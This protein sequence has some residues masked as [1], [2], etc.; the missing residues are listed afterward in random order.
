[1][2]LG[3]QGFYNV[4]DHH[5]E[6]TKDWVVV[7]WNLGNRC[8]YT[9]S[10]CPSILNDGSYGW[11][12]FEVVK[13]FIDAVAFH[14]K[15]R[16]VYYEFT[17]G[18]V[19]LWK[20][21]V[22]TAEYIKSIGHDIG[23]ISN[24]SRTIRWWEQNKDK[25]DHVCLSFHPEFATADHYLEVVKIMSNTCRTHCNIMMHTDM[26]KFNIG[27]E[28][29]QK[30]V[31]ECENISLALQP[32]VIDFGE[33][34]FPYTPE[35]LSI[36]D[37]QFEDYGKHIKHTKEYKLYR[38]SMD[39]IDTVNDLKQNSSAH[40]FIADNKNNWKG[41][42]C[43]AG[44]EQIIVDFNGTVWRGWCRVGGSFGTIH[45][46]HMCDFPTDPVRCN[47]SYCHCNFDIMCKKVLPPHRYEVLDEED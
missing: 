18:E 15:P 17:G 43:W 4:L 1:M 7:N 8:N 14:Y 35:Q 28:L 44:V 38:G 20:D 39:M 30:L 37:R 5:H 10:Y 36:I 46:P 27:K 25:F 12:D 23:F 16:K 42:D 40:R 2:A 24:G 6:E 26:D 3:S 22:K 47:K 45:E 29:A 19:T 32:L 41:W 21:F 34:R 13:G 31:D 11:N 33:E 9:C